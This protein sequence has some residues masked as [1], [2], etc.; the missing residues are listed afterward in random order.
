MGQSIRDIMT[1]DPVSLSAS[2]PVTD[3]A[4]YMKDRD[5]GDVIVLD[6]GDIY[7]VLTDR[8]IVVRVL[9]TGQDPSSTKIAEVCTR[10]I[11]SV[12]PDE[13]VDKTVELMREKAVR[14]IPVVEGGKA[15]GMVSIGDLALERDPKSALAD[16]SAARPNN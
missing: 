11:T 1:P 5:I 4:R 16:I 9:A 6:D 12:S 14:R 2:S 13:D 3:A 10:Q 8:D 15:V 7:G